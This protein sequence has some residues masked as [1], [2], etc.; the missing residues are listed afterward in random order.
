MK[1]CFSQQYIIN[2]QSIG[3]LDL[4]KGSPYVEVF[5]VFWSKIVKTKSNKLGQRQSQTP[6]SCAF[7]DQKNLIQKKLWVPKIFGSEE[8]FGQK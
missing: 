7:W 8:I 6:L 4:L 5:T 3:L 1:K 2:I